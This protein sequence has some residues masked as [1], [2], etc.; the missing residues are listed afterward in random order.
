VAPPSRDTPTQLCS[1]HHVGA[2]W[3]EPYSSPAVTQSASA[4]AP[5]GARAS[6][7][8]AEKT[9]LC[10]QPSAAASV[11]VGHAATPLSWRQ[12]PSSA[13][14]EMTSPTAGALMTFM[15]SSSW[16]TSALAN[17]SG[18]AGGAPAAARA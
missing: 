9:Q 3:H 5:P 6:V 14:P 2:P 4:V 16:P 13:A 7:R 15:H 17:C 12:P 10:A 8:S 18:A 11:R 1:P